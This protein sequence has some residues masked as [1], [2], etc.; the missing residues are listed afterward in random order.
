MSGTVCV[1]P[2]WRRG[3]G[4]AGAECAAIE[5]NVNCTG[6]FRGR[7]FGIGEATCIRGNLAT[8]ATFLNNTSWAISNAPCP[9]TRNYSPADV[10]IGG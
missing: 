6:R 5:P 2:R 1:G 9:M 7:N 3:G 4:R 10:L 8:C